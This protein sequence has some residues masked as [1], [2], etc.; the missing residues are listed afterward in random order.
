[1]AQPFNAIIAKQTDD[2]RGTSTI[3]VL[4]T[5]SAFPN[6]RALSRAMYAVNVEAGQSGT[7]GVDV[8][9]SIGGTTYTIAGLTSISAAGNYILYP[10]TYG[11]DG[12][13]DAVEAAVS[14]ATQQ[15]IDIVPPSAVMFRSN[16]ATAGVTAVITVS[17]VLYANR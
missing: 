12:A 8:V 10:R 16:V 6:A 15:I 7:F 14:V 17:A 13:L 5:T 1:M 11:S 4:S 2:F 3:S 9:G